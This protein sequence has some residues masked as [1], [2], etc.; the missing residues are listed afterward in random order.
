MSR[1]LVEGPGLR[2]G[3]GSLRCVHALGLDSGTGTAAPSLT[4]TLPISPSTR[5]CHRPSR[6]L[7]SP[8]H[9][10][11]VIASLLFGSPP[12][13]RSDLVPHPS[14]TDTTSTQALRA[15]YSQ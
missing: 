14:K 3:L 2:P 11:P 13:S 10:S 12:S 8:R 5:P 4:L 9:P 15:R 6:R 1:A 7:A